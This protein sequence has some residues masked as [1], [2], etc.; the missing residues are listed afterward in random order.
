M[1]AEILS[2]L[3]EP[4]SEEQDVLAQNS[5]PRSLYTKSGRFIIERRNMSHLSLGESTA[6]VSLRPHP[7]FR[8]FPYHSHDYMEMM[9][10]VSGS[11]VH[12]VEGKE[13]RLET[14]DLIL[15]AK[16][17]AHAIPAVGKDDIGINVIISTDLFETLFHTLRQNSRFGG[18]QFEQLL[19]RD[20][21]PYCVFHT[22]GTVAVPNI[23]ESMID[24]VLR[25]GKTDQYLLQQSLSL[26]LGYLAEA[27]EDAGGETYTADYR[28]QI[29]KKIVHYIQTSFSTATLTEAAQMLG[30]SAPYVSRLCKN[31]FGINFQELVMQER[32]RAACECLR[33]TQMPIGDIILQVGYENSSY[34]HKEFKKRYHVTPKEYRKAQGAVMV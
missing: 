1:R 25:K 15:L 9:Y 28:E 3:S 2:Y 6:A 21:V 27:A 33:T 31:L 23:M 7:R 8:D 26:L 11:I 5:P 19:R 24:S 18:K 20:G 4:T 34:F 17:T 30:L 12:V 22:R 10:V 13:I 14:D 29:K 16:H 32:F